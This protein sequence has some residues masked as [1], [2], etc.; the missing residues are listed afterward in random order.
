MNEKTPSV[1]LLH[2]NDEFAIRSFLEERLKPRMGD[3]TTMDITSI[4]IRERSIESIKTETQTVPFL[5]ER[6][7]IILHGLKSK[8]D[9]R[10]KNLIEKFTSLLDNLPP[11][12]ALVIIEDDLLENK[13]WLMKW[14]QKNRDRSWTQTFSLPT[15]PAMTTWI[16]TQAGEMG[17]EIELPAAELLAS[18]IDEDPRLAKGEIEKLLS[19]VNFERIVTEDDVKNLVA[20][21]RQGDIFEMVDAIGYGD[22]QKA[23]FMLRR[24]LEDNRA[25]T[26][27]GMIIRQF[28]LL[29][30]VRQQLDDDPSLDHNAIAEVIGSHPYPIKKIMP[31]AKLFNL[32]QLKSIYNQLS[33]IDR[34]IKTFQLEEELALDLLVA[35]LTQ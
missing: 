30:Q 35:S 16:Q 13:H 21:V 3:E 7:M 11:T 24:L 6:R 2:G 10:S 23:I 17:G 26:L 15:G 27:F 18:Y 1:Y 4:D 32:E 12:T 34:S 22:G 28:R 29:I 19:Y 25:L 9:N 8:I 20:D 14:I 5:T 31:Q 33:E